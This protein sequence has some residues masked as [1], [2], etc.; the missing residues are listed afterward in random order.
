MEPAVN[1]VTCTVRR[2]AVRTAFYGCCTD[3][4]AEYASAR[5]SPEP[6]KPLVTPLSITAE[7][8]GRVPRAYVETTLD[9]VITLPAQRRMRETLPCDAVCTLETDHSPFLS[10]PDALAR[11]LIS[12]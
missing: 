3:E 9:R 11:M 12:I 10:Q 6:L 5:L 2:S 4:D 1:G 8:Y 7:R